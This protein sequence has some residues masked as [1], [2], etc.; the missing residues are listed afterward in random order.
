MRTT[1]LN[2]ISSY[3]IEYDAWIIHDAKQTQFKDDVTGFTLVGGIT[4]TVLIASIPCE[5]N[6]GCMLLR[7][8]DGNIQEY[9]SDTSELGKSL[10][11]LW[12][13]EKELTC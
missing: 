6:D 11:I 13:T 2:L 8:K 10:M 3:G 7:S 4:P 1:K 12:H 9:R 5:L